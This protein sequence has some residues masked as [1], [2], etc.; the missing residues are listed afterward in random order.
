[1]KVLVKWIIGFWVLLYMGCQPAANQVTGPS[2][3]GLIVAISTVAGNAGLPANGTSQATIKVEVYRQSGELV[4][5]ATVFLTTT[6]GTLG[7]ANLTTT[8]GVAVTT[9]TSGTTPGT[10]YITATVENVSAT[11]YVQFVKF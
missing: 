10:A 5:G 8:N 9:L 4:N 2:A 6:L 1:M 3:S 11:A 7:S